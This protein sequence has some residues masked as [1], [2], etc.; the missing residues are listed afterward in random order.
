M[1]YIPGT[2]VQR[3][4]GYVFIKTDAGL[5]AEHRWIAQQKIVGR[6][7]RKGECVIRRNPVRD[8]NRPENLVV[9]QHALT[10]FALLPKSRVIY[11]P[12]RAK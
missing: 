8:D 5:M 10:K 9:V 6:I 1:N 4:D 11:V 3:R 2:R 12:K 7:L